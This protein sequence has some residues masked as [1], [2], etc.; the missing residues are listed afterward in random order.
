MF[1]LSKLRRLPSRRHDWLAGGC[2]CVIIELA[3]DILIYAVVK[4]TKSINSSA[5]HRLPVLKTRPRQFPP[6]SWHIRHGVARH[7]EGFTRNVKHVTA[8]KLLLAAVDTY[9]LVSEKQLR[10]NSLKVFKHSAKLHVVVSLLYCVYLS[11][12]GI[13]I[14]FLVVCS[15]SF[16]LTWTV[17][18]YCP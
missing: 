5:T 9:R 10:L 16:S 3:I 11:L 8:D 17:K 15:A 7:V 2:V 18:T 14:L 6:V 4:T 12:F 1:S 13:S